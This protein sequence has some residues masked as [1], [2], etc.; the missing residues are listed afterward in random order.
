MQGIAPTQATIGRISPPP[1]GAP[2]GS[3]H[4][5]RSR[6]TI[7]GIGASRGTV[8]GISSVHGGER[9]IVPRMSMARLL[10]RA[11]AAG[12]SRMRRGRAVAMGA[13]AAASAST[14]AKKKRLQRLRLCRSQLR[15]ESFRSWMNATLEN[16]TM[17]QIVD[18]IQITL[19]LLLV[20]LSIWLNWDG[21]F[22]AAEPSW[23]ETTEL[24]FSIVFTVEYAA[25]LYA[26]ENRCAY[27]VSFFALVDLVTVLPVY[28]TL[29]IVGNANGAEDD[30]SRVRSQFLRP[31]RVLRA[32]RI[33]RAYRL[34]AFST[35][36]IQR[37]MSVVALTVVSLVVCTTGIIQALEYSD[38]PDDADGQTLPFLDA[39]YYIIVTITTVGYGD[40][41]PKSETGRIT[42]MVMITATMVLI[43][44]QISK[45][46]QMMAQRSIYGGR[47]STTGNKA[48]VIVCGDVTADSLAHFLREFFH[49]DTALANETAVVLAP[50]EPS[51]DMKRLIMNSK[52]DTRVKYL[53]GSAM[54][55]GDLLRAGADRARAV[56][57]M[58][59]KFSMDPQATDTEA[60]LIAA[61]VRLF[62]RT[63]PVSAQVVLSSNV[64]HVQLSGAN[65]FVCVERFKQG[66][67]A[68]STMIPGMCALVSNLV[69]T[70][71]SANDD[72]LP[73]T[74]VSEY[75]R[76]STNELYD[77]EFPASMQG[78]SFADAAEIL[79]A[80]FSAI[81]I[82]VETC[83][84][85]E[86]A[87]SR[88]F[89]SQHAAPVSSRR[90]RSRRTDRR[91]GRR[92]R[93]TASMEST[94]AFDAG[95]KQASE[96]REA[97]DL[98]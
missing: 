59:D 32:L 90:S 15:G 57:C 82:A 97:S 8:A 39:M 44:S 37:Q 66:L 40:I 77:A 98:C 78:L 21:P 69:S 94:A 23:M 25:R 34:L 92:A 79:Y 71:S 65:S 61:S 12:T 30:I 16:S 42:I 5:V 36:A 73:S 56:F 1:H 26:A 72:E 2:A 19:S 84:P 96:M 70:V 47:V 60:T 87:Q 11:T 48:H 41:S 27:V 54:L 14:Q 33:L 86:T 83:G 89:S 67:I 75:F 64:R 88:G 20:G 31:I 85:V 58:L 7:A 13:L 93:S 18:G 4:S 22:T 43:P 46:S 17:G 3:P 81:L 49:A 63:V 53:Q 38:D 95:G 74:W 91:S 35:S 28:A 10:D 45:L 52:Y 80:E 9:A 68:Q 29:A 62:N 6:G 51:F 50:R 24:T 55:D 76:G